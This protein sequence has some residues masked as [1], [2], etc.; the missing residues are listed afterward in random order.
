MLVFLDTEFTDFIDCELISIGMVSED[1]Q[2]SLYLEVQ[3][4]DRAKC[5][6]FVQTAVWSRLGCIDGATVRKTEVATRLRDWFASLPHSVTIA[7]DSQYDR[8]LLADALDGEW[9]A[10]FEGWFDLRPFL[11]KSEF[12]RAVVNYHIPERPWHHALFDARAHREGWLAWNDQ[13]RRDE[14][15]Q[16]TR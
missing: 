13:K 7:C 9:P 16:S 2:H 12:N 5:N 1:G 4:F 3:D 6:A 11:E 10:N 15:E 14:L 8:D